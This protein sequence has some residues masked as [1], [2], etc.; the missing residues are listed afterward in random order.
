MGVQR[1]DLFVAGEVV[2]ELKV[3]PELTKLDKAQTISYLKVTEK[4]VGLLCN[5]GASRPHFERLFFQQRTTASD[6][7]KRIVASWPES[8]IMPELTE[9]VIGA[10]YEVHALLGPGFVYRIYVNAV[11]QELKMRGLTAVLHH[12]FEVFYHGQSIGQI[13]FQH[14]EVEGRLLIFPV[15]IQNLADIRIEN[16]KA[17]LRKR[18]LPLGIVANFYPESLEFMV[19]RV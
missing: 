18:Q 7:T 11:Y 14:V 16:M 9:A 17:W 15:A 12:M 8:Y 2:V 10:V 13:K 1:L 6:D 4:E 5:F 3:R 19:L